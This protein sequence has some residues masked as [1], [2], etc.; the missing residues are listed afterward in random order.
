[1]PSPPIICPRCGRGRSA[2]TARL[3]LRAAVP[4]PTVGE[5]PHL[6]ETDAVS[7][8]W[9]PGAGFD[10]VHQVLALPEH[11]A[12]TVIELPERLRATSRW[13]RATVLPV[14][15]D[16]PRDRVVL[17]GQQPFTRAG[18]PSGAANRHSPS[19]AAGS[20]AQQC[21][22]A[23]GGI[24]VEVPGRPP[25][26]F[27]AGKTSSRSAEPLPRRRWRIAIRLPSIEPLELG[28]LTL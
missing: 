3:H 22:S 5:D 7:L 12:G 19:L 20:H 10:L 25:H 27:L 9:V 21:G 8:F 1:M 2:T 4:S 16:V 11:A 14:A 6:L 15:R 18:A 13:L 17:G 26:C 28:R 23:I 24:D